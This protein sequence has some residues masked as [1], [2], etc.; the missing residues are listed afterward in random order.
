MY[1]RIIVSLFTRERQETHVEDRDIRIGQCFESRQA[2][3]IVLGILLSDHDGRAKANFFKLLRK[4]RH[5]Q[6]RAVVLR[7]DDKDRVRPGI[8]F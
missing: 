5:R 8:R 4:R 3:R 2:G 1:S 7:T 6:V